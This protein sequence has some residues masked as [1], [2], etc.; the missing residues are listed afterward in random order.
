MHWNPRPWSRKR[1]QPLPHA[2]PRHAMPPRWGTA[3]AAYQWGNSLF[4]NCEANALSWMSHSRATFAGD[5]TKSY[6]WHHHF[7][8]KPWRL[9]GLACA[10]HRA[11][12]SLNTKGVTQVGEYSTIQIY[13]GVYSGSQKSW[14]LV[15]YFMHY[16]S[17]LFWPTVHRKRKICGWTHEKNRFWFKISDHSYSLPH[18]LREARSFNPYLS[19]AK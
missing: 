2:A 9:L 10:S 14:P 8:E 7:F 12:L 16:W 1:S 3:H 15:A 11:P 4:A 13:S 19:C 6:N 18:T 17:W 5:A